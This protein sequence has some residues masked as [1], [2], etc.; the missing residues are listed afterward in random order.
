MVRPTSAQIQNIWKVL[1][2]I[3]QVVFRRVLVDAGPLVAICNKRDQFHEICV[4]TLHN[5]GLPMFTTWLVIAEAA[6]L[7][8]G[9]SVS[10][11][12]LIAG[13]AAGL[14]QIMLLTEDDLP[15]M[16]GL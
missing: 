7:L 11:Q 14:Y 5:I 2:V 9:Y 12:Q 6:H 15:A 8:R 3:D 4:D 16:A 10:L 1:G 13:L